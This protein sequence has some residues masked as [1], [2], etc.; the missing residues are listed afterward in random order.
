M[1]GIK[2]D[3]KPGD[4]IIYKG[5]DLEHWREKFTGDTCAQVFL[6]YN[7]KQKSLKENKFDRTLFRTSIVF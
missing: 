7:S 3:L 6:H 1:K 2:I 4:M 5:S